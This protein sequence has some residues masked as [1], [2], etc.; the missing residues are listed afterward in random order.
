MKSPLHGAGGLGTGG[1]G[2][3]SL[4]TQGQGAGGPG[5][6]GRGSGGCGLEYTAH[7]PFIPHAPQGPERGGKKPT[8]HEVRSQRGPCPDGVNGTSSEVHRCL[9]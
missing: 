1:E 8:R 6:W 5:A 4:G 3:E 7:F 9:P 2:T